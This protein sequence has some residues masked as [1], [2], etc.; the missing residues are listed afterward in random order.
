[1]PNLYSAQQGAAKQVFNTALPSSITA[2][3]P[4]DIL[5]RKAYHFVTKAADIAGATPET[6]FTVTGDVVLAVVGIVKTA[7]TTSDAITV[8]VGVAGNTAG[9]IAQVADATGLALNE[10]YH[11]ATPDATIELESV[12]A[13]R[14]VSNGQDVILTTTG[15][16][17]DGDITFYCRWYPLSSDGSVVAA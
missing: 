7:V 12:W 17:T 3:S 2:L 9:I 8:E 10:I 16:V 15:T 1:M 14:I 5:N 4:Y 11:D 13:D 6:L